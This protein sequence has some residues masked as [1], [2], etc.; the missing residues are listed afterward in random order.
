MQAKILMVST[1]LLCATLLG[2]CGAAVVAG[3]GA[4]A[5]YIAHQEGYRVQN[6]VTKSGKSTKKKKEAQ[7]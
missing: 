7:P 4:A 6:P 1:A 2:G 3:A 5:G